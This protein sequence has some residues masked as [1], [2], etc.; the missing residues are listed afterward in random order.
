MPLTRSF[1]D[2]VQARVNRDP[3]YR[4][5]LFQEAVETLLEG[6]VETSKTIL[7]DYINATVGFKELSEATGIPSTSLMRMFGPSGNPNL[8]NMFTVI[9]ELQEAANLY[10]RV[11]VV[12]R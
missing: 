12:G 2:T 1:K 3:E 9:K 11:E 7:R 6:D 4:N 8:R 10:L 5:A